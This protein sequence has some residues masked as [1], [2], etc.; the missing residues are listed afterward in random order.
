MIICFCP[1]GFIN[2]F[3]G[4]ISQAFFNVIIF[5]IIF[6]VIAVI[7]LQRIKKL[8]EQLNVLSTKNQEL[9][10]L[11]NNAEQLNKNLVQ[12]SILEKEQNEMLIAKMS[13]EIH[14]C[15]NGI[16]GMANLLRDTNLDAE[17]QINTAIIIQRTK[18]LLESAHDSFNTETNAELN[19]NNSSEN[20]KLNAWGQLEKEKISKEFF[21]KYPFNILVAE[22]DE[23]NQQLAIRLLAK[24]GYAADIA[25][26]GK[27]ALDMVSEKNYDIILMDV[28]MPE[29][30]GFEATKMIRLCL[31]VQPLIIAVT[32][33]A[34]SGD[35]DNCLEAGMDDYICK[36]II[37]EDLAALFEKWGKERKAAFH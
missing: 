9:Q 19:M 37:I 11:F 30:D 28:L 26:N 5:L 29:M 4:F 10:E 24:L 17:Q 22:D 31:D 36:P 13:Y 3:F 8:K 35:K 21:Q 16:M 14:N 18:M 27:E 15:V 23:I 20:S 2:I 33:S 32:A 12:E 1:P 25:S 7:F 6:L 34:M